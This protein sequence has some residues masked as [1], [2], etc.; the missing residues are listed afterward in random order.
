MQQQALF[1]VEPINRVVGLLFLVGQDG[2]GHSGES[3][4]PK[5]VGVSRVAAAVGVNAPGDF[6]RLSDLVDWREMDAP[7]FGIGRCA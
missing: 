4:T 6:R 3:A 7:A 5:K 1:G 2:D